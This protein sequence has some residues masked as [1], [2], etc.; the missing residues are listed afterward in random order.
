MC[1]ITG[2]FS[3]EGVKQQN[4]HA[5]T[6]VIAHR[7]PDAEGYFIANSGKVC[8][9][10]RRL[11]IIDLSDTANQPMH[12]ASGRYVMVYNGEVY[13][14][15]ELRNKLPKHN[16]LTH[17]DT[18]VILELFANFG[19]E[20]FAWLNGMFTIAVYDKTVEK[21]FVARDQLGIKPL[22][23]YRDENDF[24]FSSELKGIK[25]Y[26]Q[27]DSITLNV[28]RQAI[29]YFLHLGFI[30]E[31]MS[32]YQDVF[33]F[34]A[35]NYAVLESNTGSINFYRYW[36]AKES[37]LKSPV[38]SEDAA[39]K[40][41]KELVYTAVQ[42]QMVSDVPLGTFLSGG[43]DSS[44]VTAIASKVTTNKINTF[45]IGFNEAKYDESVYAQK[46]AGH[47]KTNHHPL[48]VSVNE[49][50]ELVPQLLEVYDEPFADSSAFPTMLVSKLARK[51]VTVALSGDGG[52]ELFQ[53]YGMYTWAGRLQQPFI[54]AAHKPLFWASKL[55]NDRYKRA[56]T[57]F[58]YASEDRIKSHIFSQEQYYFSEYELKEVLVN[59]QFNFEEIN[60]TESFARTMI[61]A[62]QQAFWDIEHYLKDDLLVK[63]D[64]ASMR[65]SLESRVPL[66]DINLVEFAL[67]LSYDLKVRKDFGSKYLM[68][69]ALYELVPREIF[70]RPKRGFA[71]PLKEWLKGP[72]SYL[73][74]NY[75]SEK[76]ID[77]YNYVKY[78]TVNTLLN[79]FNKGEDYLYNRLWT[80]VVLHWWL[81]ENTR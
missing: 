24:I 4:I 66:L 39:F 25:A 65:Y 40:Q 70:E 54:R 74:T 71:I 53:G 22:F 56:G 9:G 51:H 27:H 17:S 52:D 34:P 31:P 1:G 45:S 16:W 47:L 63:V 12:S 79:R 76:V 43:I 41:Y 15:N 61:P 32:I 81:E 64:R 42:S 48:K 60:K 69:K 2:A 44:L 80:L 36:D 6:G 75:L 5:A 20:C 10:H 11:S 26:L 18:E 14:F 29:P 77:K 49:V 23:Y 3:T 37:I 8:L 57:L 7:G 78:S 46:V 38:E 62:E 50:M 59:S 68:K 21:L 28:N 13:N 73:I 55:M 19:T 35:A 33:K 30:P 67:N 72:L 58:N